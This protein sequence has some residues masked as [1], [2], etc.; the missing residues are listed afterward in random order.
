VQ[1]VKWLGHQG[2]AALLLTRCVRGDL[3]HALKGARPTN[4]PIDETHAVTNELRVAR[5]H[6]SLA[7]HHHGCTFREFEVSRVR[8]PPGKCA[9]VPGYLQEHV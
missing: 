9:R 4:T 6:I 8:I 5:A 7:R 1:F 2:W 3:M